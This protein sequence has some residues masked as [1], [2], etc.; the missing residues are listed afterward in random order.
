MK[1][2]NPASS[3]CPRRTSTDTPACRAGADRRL[4]HPLLEDLFADKTNGK[5]SDREGRSKSPP[6]RELSLAHGNLALYEEIQQQRG[7]W[8]SKS[9]GAARAQEEWRIA[10]ATTR[11]RPAGSC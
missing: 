2:S 5:P 10:D 8:N 7:R 11:S 9:T 6:W 1:R 4:G 3:A